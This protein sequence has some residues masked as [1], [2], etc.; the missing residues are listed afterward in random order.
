MKARIHLLALIPIVLITARIVVIYPGNLAHGADWV[1]MEVSSSVYGV[2]DGDTFDTFPVGRVRLA[3]VNAPELGEPGGDAAKEALKGLILNS[4]VYLDVDDVGVMD[5]YNRLVCVVYRRYNSTHLLNVNKWLVENH[6]VEVIDYPNEFNPHTWSLYIYYPETKLP[7]GYDQLL[8]NYMSLESDYLNLNAE[9]EKLN[10]EFEKLKIEY[11]SLREVFEKLNSTYGDLIEKYNDLVLKYDK[12][13]GDYDA[14]QSS[15]NSFKLDYSS[16]KNM[17]EKTRIE[18]EKLA[19]QL[20]VYMMLTYLFL[21]T[22]LMFGFS[23]VYLLRKRSKK[24]HMR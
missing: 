22:T 4:R 7:E 24:A 20:N 15:Y 23:T 14:L 10:M 21:G 9:A 8:Q 13:K 6:Y 17:Y 5:R 3:D 18:N 12:I 16:L 19:S 11:S 1:E 2:I